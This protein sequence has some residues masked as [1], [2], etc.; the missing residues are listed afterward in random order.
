MTCQNRVEGIRTGEG[1]ILVTHGELDAATAEECFTSMTEIVEKYCDTTPV[2]LPVVIDLCGVRFLSCA[3]VRVVL[4][5]A[6]WGARAGVP[7]GMT[8]PDEAPVR[9]VLDLL[10][11]QQSVPVM[12]CRPAPAMHGIDQPRVCGSSAAAAD[13]A[14][15]RADGEQRPHPAN[16]HAHRS[17]IRK[18][19]NTAHE[20]L[21]QR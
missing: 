9:R 12:A 4:R 13:E 2:P 5:L 15:G 19:N 16:A 10:A 8:V 1:L 20:R 17:T 18:T 3:G 21:T 6:G 11:V 7:V 14:A